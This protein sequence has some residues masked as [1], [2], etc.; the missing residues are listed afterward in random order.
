MNPIRFYFEW[1]DAKHLARTA[2]P[3]KNQF[4][5]RF[6][7]I[8]RVVLFITSI[9]SGACLLGLL[10]AAHLASGYTVL[11]FVFIYL[12]SVLMYAWVT[13]ALLFRRY[14]EDHRRQTPVK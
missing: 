4:D 8:P 14:I 5:I 9:L 12:F 13:E 7:R 1:H 10:I 3:R 2:D 11:A 6:L